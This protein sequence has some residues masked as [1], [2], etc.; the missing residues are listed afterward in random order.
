MSLKLN[1]NSLRGWLPSIAAAMLGSSAAGLGVLSANDTKLQPK[2]GLPPVEQASDGAIAALGRQLFNDTR[3]SATGR[4]ACATCHVPK[5]GFTQS[6]RPT[7]EG[8][9]GQALRRNASTLLNVAFATP[10]MHDGA[11][12][13]LEVQALTPLFAPDEMANGSFEDLER[14]L[15]SLPEY[16]S[17]FQELFGR[18]PKVADAGRSLAAYQRTLISGNSPFDRWQFGGDGSAVTAEAKAGFDLFTGKAGCSSCHLTGKD[19]AL[20]TDNLMHNT[21]VGA[22]DRD[23]V[24]RARHESATVDFARAGDRGRN[25]VTGDAADLFKYR[26]PTLRNVAITAPYMHDGSFAT[27]EDV[28]R[29]YVRGGNANPNLDAAIKP[30]QLNDREVGALVAFLKSLTGS[31]VESLAAEATRPPTQP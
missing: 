6:S 7:P 22:R 31:N 23:Q 3:L 18:P 14:K 11:A 25:E 2:L 15:A 1:V 10:L 24:S 19:S 26:T 28:V 30:L 13:S 17:A 8:R 27:L 5:E 29:F 16:A 20:L 4:M 21:G 12:P 9:D